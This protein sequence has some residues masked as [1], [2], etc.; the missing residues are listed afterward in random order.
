MWK[1]YALVV[2]FN[3]E[4]ALVEA[5]QCWVCE[6]VREGLEVAGGGSQTNPSGYI[7]VWPL[8]PH[9]ARQLYQLGPFPATGFIFQPLIMRIH[10]AEPSQAPHQPVSEG[11]HWRFLT[12]FAYFF[13]LFWQFFMCFLWFWQKFNQ[14]FKIILHL[15]PVPPPLPLWRLCS[16]GKV[17]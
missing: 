10:H 15:P 11:W 5:W 3:L 16:V 2:A 6:G 1:G 9:L 4:K 7:N 14:C 8:P 13:L 17:K 12:N